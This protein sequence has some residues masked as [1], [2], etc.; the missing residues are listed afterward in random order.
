MDKDEHKSNNPDRHSNMVNDKKVGVIGVWHLGAVYSACMAELGY[1]V[2]GIDDDINRVNNLNL[3]IP[4]VFEPGLKELISSNIERRRLTYTTNIKTIEDYS[5][6]M[7]TFD[8]P[9]N[10]NDDVDLSSIIDSCR[11]LSANLKN[12]TTIIVSSQVPVGTCDYI[13]LVIKQLNPVIEFDI[14]YCPENLRLGKAIDYFMKPDRIVIGAD[15]TFT[16]D[17]V[18]EFLSVIAAPKLR[19]DL[20]SA[21]MTKH[22]LNAFIATSISFANEIANLCDEVGAD[23]MSVASALKSDSRIG[24]GVPL[25]P[26]LAFSGGTLARD[27]KILTKLGKDNNYDTSL[28]NGVLEVNRRQNSLV[29]KKLRKIFGMVSGLTVGVLGLTYKAGT[30]TL[31]RSASLEIIEELTANQITVKAY[32]PKADPEEVR[33]HKNFE[34]LPDPYTVAKDSDALVILTDWTEF[35]NL[36]FDLIKALMK[37]PVIIDGK[38]LLNSQMLIQKGFIYSGVGRGKTS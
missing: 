25:H 15:K 4:P 12:G 35:V 38:N 2:I 1:Q 14:A 18:E 30:S 16:L 13:N 32:D 19:M 3:G 31:R 7:I 9:V 5:Y 11:K 24:Q 27:L 6:V 28:I 10:E 34:F 37:K 17:T 36:D 26:G 21:E 29:T 23:A 22:A 33:L 20:R 8:T